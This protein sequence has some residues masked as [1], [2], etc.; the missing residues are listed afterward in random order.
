MTGSQ[1]LWDYYV[2]HC[3]GMFVTIN[4]TIICVYLSIK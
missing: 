3:F 2:K 4:H 1:F